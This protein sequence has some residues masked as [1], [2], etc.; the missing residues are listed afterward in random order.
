MRRV[1]GSS[2]EHNQDRNDF[3]DPSIQ[4]ALH[5]SYNEVYCTDT[6]NYSIL[7]DHFQEIFTYLS[8]MPTN[9][10]LHFIRIGQ[11]ARNLL[12]SPI[13]VSYRLSQWATVYQQSPK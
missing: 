3:E 9:L 12:T 1:V 6:A 13:T 10:S 2:R 7:C 8:R 4:P 5:A 11:T